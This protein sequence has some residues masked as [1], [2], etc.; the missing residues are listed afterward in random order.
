MSQ[1][2]II[3]SEECHGFI[4]VAANMDAAFRFVAKNFLGDL[5]DEEEQKYISYPI[6]MEK[7]NIDDPVQ[8]MKKMYAEN[9]DCFDGMFY[10][11]EDVLI[12]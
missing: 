10:F 5:W 2:I 7:Y 12:E 8:L 1:K 3:I 9:E 11:S 4:G 6:L